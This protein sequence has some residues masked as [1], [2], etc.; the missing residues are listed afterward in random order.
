M[1]TAI[2]IIPMPP[3]HCSRALQIKIPLDAFSI[4]FKIVEPVVVIPEIDSKM[5]SII[6]IDKE[7]KNNGSDPNNP[8]NNQA[9]FVKRKASFKVNSLLLFLWLDNQSET[10]IK[11]VNKEDLAK[12]SQLGS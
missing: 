5:E 12:D 9:P 3:S 4:L 1:A 8:M 6:E 2:T 10:P 7:E 11:P